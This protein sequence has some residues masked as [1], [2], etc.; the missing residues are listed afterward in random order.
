MLDRHINQKI[1]PQVPVRDLSPAK[2]EIFNR[3]EF[4]YDK[5]RDLYICPQEK[6]TGHRAPRTM[7]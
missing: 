3:D 2:K 6:S 7:A 4:V 1:E 5:G